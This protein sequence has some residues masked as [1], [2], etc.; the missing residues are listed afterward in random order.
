MFPNVIESTVLHFG[1]SQVYAIYI[2]SFA[3]ILQICCFINT[4]F[5]VLY[6]ASGM[7]HLKEMDLSRCSKVNDAGIKHLLSIRT[8]ETLCISETSVTT[9][10]VTLLSSLKKISKLEL[11]GLFI[12]DTALVSLR[13]FISF[14]H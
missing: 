6:L 10:G 5:H 9:N 12:T 2:L 8:I 14:L 4:L 11:G 1:L 3:N 7:N 13:V